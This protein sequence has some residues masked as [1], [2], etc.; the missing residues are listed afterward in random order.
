[1]RFLA[2]ENCEPLVVKTLRDFGHDVDYVA[3][4]APGISDVEILQRNIAQERVIVTEDAD[5]SSLVF[6]ALMPA[7]S[8]IYIRIPPE[9]QAVKSLRIAELLDVYH[10]QLVGSIAVVTRSKFR[11]RRFAA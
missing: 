6:Q 4:S 2:D 5:F 11:F 9:F 1:M 7:Y 3:E 8:I 10:Q